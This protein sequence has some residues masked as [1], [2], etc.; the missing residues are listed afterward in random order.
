MNP[1]CSDYANGYRLPGFFET[2]TGF[3]DGGYVLD[4]I[5]QNPNDIGRFIHVVGDLGIMSNAFQSNYVQNIVSV[6]AGFYSAVDPKSA[7]WNKAS[8]QLVPN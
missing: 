3:Y 5:K 7:I 4:P 2:S 1:L 6:V 8:G